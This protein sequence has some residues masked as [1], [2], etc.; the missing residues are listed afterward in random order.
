MQKYEIS[1]E[2]KFL[3]NKKHRVLNEPVLFYNF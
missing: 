1:L 3:Y 2:N